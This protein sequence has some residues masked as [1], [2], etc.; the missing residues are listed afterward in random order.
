MKA[1]NLN[2]VS[3]IVQG[4]VSFFLNPN[5]QFAVKSGQFSTAAIGTYLDVATQLVSQNF[6][7]TA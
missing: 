2:N 1:H 6:N 5:I 4:D 3:G 7:I